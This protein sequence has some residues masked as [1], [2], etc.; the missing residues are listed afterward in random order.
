MD[1]SCFRTISPHLQI[2]FNCIFSVALYRPVTKCEAI[3][4]FQRGCCKWLVGPVATSSTV[5]G[6]KAG[7]RFHGS[8]L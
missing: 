3:C 5:F 4:G 2:G 8:Q 1:A 6:S 7:S